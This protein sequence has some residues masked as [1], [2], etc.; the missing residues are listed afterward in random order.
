MGKKEGDGNFADL[1]ILIPCRIDS[2]E[3][4]ENISCIIRF[5]INAGVGNISILESGKQQEYFPDHN[6]H[7]IH[8]Q[9]IE[10]HDAV[11]P[12][13]KHINTL[14]QNSKASIVAAWDTDVVVS[15][16]QVMESYR[17]VKDGKAFM[18][19]PYDGRVY[20]CDKEL[21]GLFR[22]R[23][24]IQLLEKAAPALPL[25]YGHLSTGGAFFVN[26]R[27]YLESGGENESFR[28]WGPEDVERVKRI[29]ISGRKV[30]FASGPMYHLWHPR[31]RTS[32]YADRQCEINNRRIF[33]ETCSN[34]IC[35]C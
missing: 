19:I 27:D 26:R 7:F 15:A 25:M 8:T 12:K 16:G 3:R 35:T 14:L 33:I 11:F 2:P 1:G 34:E 13:T 32:R 31:G 20:V 17:T 21:S 30:H 4:R 5:L 9:F 29:E 24:D 18:S 22:T 28:G 10:D 6:F 23:P